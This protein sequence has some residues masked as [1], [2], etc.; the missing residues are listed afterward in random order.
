MDQLDRLRGDLSFVRSVAD[1][2]ERHDSPAP[3]YF[4]WAA[5]VLCGFILV[6][7]RDAWV[8]WYWFVAA[9]AGFMVSAYLGW[10]HG[11]RR[12]QIDSDAGMRHILHWGG[13]TAVA[14]LVVLMPMTGVL[15]WEGT[16]P[17]MLLVLALGYFHAGIHLDRPFLWIGILMALGYLSVLFV[18]AYAW[19]VLGVVLAI[20]LVVAG[21]RET[22][23]HEAAV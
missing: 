1:G 10:R 7:V 2:A 23:L 5:L 12:G 13:M 8:R 19:T 20:A 11:R 3:I 22:R 18:T 21:L 9:P 14:F 4:L 6:D 16:G 17:A 15:A